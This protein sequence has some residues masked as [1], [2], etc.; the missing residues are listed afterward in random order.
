MSISPNYP[1]QWETSDP[2]KRFEVDTGGMDQ[3]PM[4]FNVPNTN[5][6]SLQLIVFLRRLDEVHVTG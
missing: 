5:K 4:S 2:H 6:T 1:G 3:R